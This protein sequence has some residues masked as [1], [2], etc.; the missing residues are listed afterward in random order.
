MTMNFDCDP[1]KAN[2]LKDL[3]YAEIEKIKK[4]G[5]TK[6]EVSKITLNMLKNFEQS[7]SHNSYWMNV[8][9]NYYITDIDNN[10]PKNYEEILKNLTPEDIQKFVCKLFDNPDTIDLIFKPKK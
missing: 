6:E 8:I 7:K 10:D 9:A 5:V 2:H 4:E 3:I 1:I